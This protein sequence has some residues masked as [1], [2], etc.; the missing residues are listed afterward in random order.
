MHKAVTA[1][2][3][4]SNETEIVTELRSLHGSPQPCPSRRVQNKRRSQ[5]GYTAVFNEAPVFWASKVS[6]VCFAHPKI[7]EA[8]ADMSSGAAEV[9]AAGN[10][11]QDF[12]HLSYVAEELGIGFELPFNLQI[13]NTAA[14][15]FA[16]DTVIKTKLKHIDCRQDWVRIL[17]DRTI[18]TPTH[19]D[20]KL[21]VADLFT[22]ILPADDFERLTRMIMPRSCPIQSGPQP[23][24]QVAHIMYPI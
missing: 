5:N 15:A 17:R 21:N 24:V 2:V 19:V 7:G 8:H 4:P 20:T 14:E 18:C 13:D 6:S 16:N 1:R 9:Y 3:S 23:I 10:A 12:L 11:T 22:K